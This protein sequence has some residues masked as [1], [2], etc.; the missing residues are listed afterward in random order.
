MTIRKTEGSLGV[1]ETDRIPIDCCPEFV[2]SQQEQI[3]LTVQ[4]NPL[5]HENGNVIT[6]SV[7]SA[8]PRIDFYDLDSIFQ[9]SWLID[10]IQDF[11]CPKEASFQSRFI[12]QSIKLA[13]LYEIYY[14]TDW[15]AHGVCAARKISLLPTRKRVQYSRDAL[16]ALQFEYSSRECRAVIRI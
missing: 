10:R 15:S 3:T 8:V 14:S 11:H 6:L 2:G 12:D 1:G 4:D 7:K 16:Q 9:E 5:Q 13:N